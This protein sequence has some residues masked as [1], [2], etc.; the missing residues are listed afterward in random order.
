MAAANALVIVPEDRPAV[1]A[2]TVLDA[3]RLDDD[4]HAAEPGF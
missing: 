3:V 2:G 1:P 4:G